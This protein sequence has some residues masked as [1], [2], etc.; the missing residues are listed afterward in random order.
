MCMC[1]WLC[2]AQLRGP[3]SGRTWGHPQEVMCACLSNTSPPRQCGRGECTYT[4]S[5]HTH[6]PTQSCLFVEIHM[7]ITLQVTCILCSHSSTLSSIH[8]VRTTLECVYDTSNVPAIYPLSFGE[9]G[10]IRSL[11]K[12]PVVFPKTI[13]QLVIF[14]NVIVTHCRWGGDRGREGEWRHVKTRAGIWKQTLCEHTH[15]ITL[16][17]Y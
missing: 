7:C 10:C 12:S 3:T 14:E 2:V 5:A 11:L 16:Q 17:R 8:Y 6:R 13:E 9:N 1:E 15:S 4:H